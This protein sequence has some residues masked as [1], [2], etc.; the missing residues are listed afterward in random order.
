MQDAAAPGVHVEEPSALFSAPMHY[1]RQLRGPVEQ[2]KTDLGV[3][4]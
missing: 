3:L 1:L 2:Q 4:E